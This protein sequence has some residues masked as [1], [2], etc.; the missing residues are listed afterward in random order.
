MDCQELYDEIKAALKYFGLSFSEMDQIKLVLTPNS[1]TFV[2]QQWQIT[3]N[4]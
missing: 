4:F 3:T 2:H 1:V